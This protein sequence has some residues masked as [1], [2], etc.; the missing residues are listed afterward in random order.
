MVVYSLIYVFSGSIY[1]LGTG[2]DPVGFYSY[3]Y[4]VE[5]NTPS[6]KD[7]KVYILW[8]DRY[9]ATLYGSLQNKL[10]VCFFGSIQFT[11]TCG[12]TQFF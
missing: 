8:T 2:P 4:Y 11:D 7:L 10:S 5:T 9:A 3:H 1:A 6:K 12:G